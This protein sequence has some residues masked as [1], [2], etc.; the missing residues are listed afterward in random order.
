MKSADLAT[1][2]DDVAT[3][4]KPPAVSDLGELDALSGL[5]LKEQGNICVAPMFDEFA[6]PEDFGAA[7]ALLCDEHAISCEAL[8]ELVIAKD[9]CLEDLSLLAKDHGVTHSEW[10]EIS[11]RPLSDIVHFID[12][13]ITPSTAGASSSSGSR[14][15]VGSAAAST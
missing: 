8:P 11:Q 5:T 13:L 15:N 12:A 3:N 10:Y 4:T 1:S 2:G 7:A 9:V 6:N 14:H